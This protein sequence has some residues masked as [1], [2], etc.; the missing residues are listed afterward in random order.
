[1]LKNC[2]GI[3]NLDENE[4]K[5][6]ELTRNRPLA[7][8]PIAGRYRIIDFILSN[9]TNA[10]IESIGIF[11]KMQSRSLM[12][13]LSNGRPWDLNRKIDGLRFFNFTTTDPCIDDIT[14]FANNIEYLYRAKQEYVIFTSSYMICNIDFKDILKNHIESDYDITMVYKKI[15]DADE[16]FCGCETLNIDEKG[17]I[18]SIGKNIGNRKNANVGMGIFIMKKDFLIHIINECISSGHYRK[19]KSF[20]YNSLDNLKV[21][22]YEFK[23]YLACINSLKSYYKRSVE[24]LDHKIN[25]E[26]FSLERPIY[27]KT[28]DEIPARYTND[29]IVKNSIIANGCLIEGTVENCIIFRRVKVSKGAMLKNCIILQNCIIGENAKLYNIITD[30]HVNIGDNKELRGDITIPLVVENNV[31]KAY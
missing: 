21:K 8:V 28:N 5:I 29:C 17:N 10:G 24:L 25:K 31:R 19:V 30:K 22:S 16:N 6:R 1:M 12:D 13:H 23:G 18:L 4:D 3:I 26:L 9:L 15:E 27:T 20:I 14:N 7:S 11:S 2:L